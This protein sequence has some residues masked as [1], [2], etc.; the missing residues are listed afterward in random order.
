MPISA[1]SCLLS[2]EGDAITL[3]VPYVYKLFGTL[4]TVERICVKYD[5]VL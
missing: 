2:V 5:V 1:N 4:L 3:V